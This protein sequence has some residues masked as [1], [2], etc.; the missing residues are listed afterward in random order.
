MVGA[1]F[2]EP[3]KGAM[4]CAPTEK[5]SLMEYCCK[6][7]AG[8]PALKLGGLN[9]GGFPEAAAYLPQQPPRLKRKKTT[10][11]TMT[12]TSQFIHSILVGEMIL[13]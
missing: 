13:S 10:A 6:T 7:S 9:W 4:T 1:R 5:S 3:L 2:I 8:G 12:I 11:A